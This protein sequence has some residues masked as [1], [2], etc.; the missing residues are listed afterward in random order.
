MN[1]VSLTKLIAVN[2]ICLPNELIEVVKDYAFYDKSSLP[3]I[4][5]MSSFKAPIN[6]TIK[7]AISRNNPRI[8]QDSVEDPNAEEYWCFGFDDDDTER[9]QLQGNNCFRCGNYNVVGNNQLLRHC[10]KNVPHIMC[11]CSTN[12]YYGWD[13]QDEIED[14]DNDSEYEDFDMSE[15]DD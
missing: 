1:I 8:F 12:I 13:N 7:H 14:F 5:K 2:A 4:K 3:Y 15:I 11:C 10:R 6:D 9:L